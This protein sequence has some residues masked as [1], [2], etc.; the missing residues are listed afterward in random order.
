[1]SIHGCFVYGYF[2]A[3][4]AE[5]IVTSEPAGLTK[6]KRL[7]IW[8]FLEKVC[9]LLFFRIFTKANASV[10]NKIDVE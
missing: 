7:A 2:C 1:M 10:K 6:P 5:L 3:K 4:I 9:Q 8:P